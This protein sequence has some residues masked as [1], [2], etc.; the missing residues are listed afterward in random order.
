MKDI[1]EDDYENIFNKIF[2]RY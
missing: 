1:N 2:K